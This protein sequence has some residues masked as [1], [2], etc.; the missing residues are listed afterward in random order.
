[1]PPHCAKPTMPM[2]RWTK[3]KN[4]PR[5]AAPLLKHDPF[6]IIGKFGHSNA[7]RFIEFDIEFDAFGCEFV[8]LIAR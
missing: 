7:A 2:R 6:S 1:M 5:K 3:P 8:V 4:D